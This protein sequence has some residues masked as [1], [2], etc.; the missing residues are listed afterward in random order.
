MRTES[1]DGLVAK[2][3]VAVVRLFGLA[4]TCPVVQDNPPDCPLYNVREMPLVQRLEWAKSR[5][6]EEAE[7]VLHNH[8]CCHRLLAKSG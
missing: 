6:R 3:D 7:A 1:A 2:E 4:I 8:S 5:T